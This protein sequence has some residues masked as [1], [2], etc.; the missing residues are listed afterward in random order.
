MQHKSLLTLSDNQLSVGGKL[1]N[2]ELLFSSIPSSHSH[3]H[4]YSHETSIVI[5][6]PMGIP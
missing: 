2:V 4:F 5:P 3:S 1:E 6:I